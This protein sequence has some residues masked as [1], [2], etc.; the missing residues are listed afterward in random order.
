VSTFGDQET[1]LAVACADGPEDCIIAAALAWYRSEHRPA[2]I[3]GKHLDQVLS[4]M[5]SDDD[6]NQEGA[7]MQI[8][9]SYAPGG[10]P[11]VMQ[12]TP[13]TE[14][15]NG[16]MAVVLHHLVCPECK[17]EITIGDFGVLDGIGKMK[18]KRQSTV[19]I[20]APPSQETTMNLWI[21]KLP[22]KCTRFV[23]SQAAGREMRDLFMQEYS[24]KKK[25]VAL[26]PIQVPTHKDELLQ[27][28]NEAYAQIDAAGVQ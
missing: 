26:E 5:S 4:T 24:V 12:Y 8:P 21:C 14:T 16:K 17:G 28:L 1:M 11:G 6:D 3:E 27:F 22:G 15:G 19:R 7:I 23:A 2:T 20:S 25:D 18:N 10:C 9:C 13:T